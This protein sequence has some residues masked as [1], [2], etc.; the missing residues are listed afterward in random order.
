MGRPKKNQSA[1]ATAPKKIPALDGLDDIVSEV[2]GLWG[3][4]LRRLSKLSRIYGFERVEPPLLEDFRLYEQFFKDT[5]GH[6]KSYLPV[7]L[8]NTSQ[9]GVRADLLPGVLR[10]YYQHKVYEKS[11][12]ISGAASNFAASWPIGP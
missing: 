8:T 11:P 3:A 7:A 1:T 10:S 12:F 9:G 6:L 4:V 2:D 5:P